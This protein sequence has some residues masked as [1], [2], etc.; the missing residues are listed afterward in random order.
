[1]SLRVRIVLYTLGR[2]IH[3]SIL[4]WDGIC[5][6]ESGYLHYTWDIMNNMAYIGGSCVR[7]SSRDHE[8]KWLGFGPIIQ[9]AWMKSL[10][11]K[12]A[13]IESMMES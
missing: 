6:Y 9:I 7:H 5:G 12:D 11:R 8:V 13:F 3:I 10:S 1:M 4:D 2:R